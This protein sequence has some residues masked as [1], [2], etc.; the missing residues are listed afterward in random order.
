MVNNKVSR[1]VDLGLNPASILKQ[2][3]VEQVMY[4]TEILIL[5]QGL[6]PYCSFSVGQFPCIHKVTLIPPS[7]FTQVTR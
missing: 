3:A 5:P 4:T 1:Q 2:W 6:C 7:G